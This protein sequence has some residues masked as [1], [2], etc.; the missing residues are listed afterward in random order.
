MRVN[1]KKL[2]NTNYYRQKVSVAT[3]S[4]CTFVSGLYPINW[5]RFLLRCSHHLT[6]H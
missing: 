3:S 4:S 1:M 5:S 6:G 2:F